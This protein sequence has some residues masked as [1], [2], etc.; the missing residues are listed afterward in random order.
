MNTAGTYTV[1]VTYKGIRN[2]ETAITFVPGGGFGDWRAFTIRAGEDIYQ[3]QYLISGCNNR[4]TDIKADMER[5][6]LV[7]SLS[8]QSNGTLQL[9]FTPQ[10]LEAED[11]FLAFADG[12]QTPVTDISSGT[13]NAV[14]ISFPP[15]T[16]E[17]ELKG[18]Y[19]IPEFSGIASLVLGM[20][21]IG[22]MTLVIMHR[23]YTKS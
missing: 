4:V 11:Q 20:S 7:I 17:I 8:T 3:I 9:R 22:I 1:I 6:S 10:I 16:D 21:V 12:V 23:N 15:G 18:D 13:A 19:L 14:Q 2:A 5:T